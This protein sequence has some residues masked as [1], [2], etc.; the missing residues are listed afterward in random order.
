MTQNKPN[1]ALF[2][3]F[4]FFPMQSEG[5]R[6]DGIPINRQFAVYF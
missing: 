3:K 1:N 2:D 4:L 5:E 6:I